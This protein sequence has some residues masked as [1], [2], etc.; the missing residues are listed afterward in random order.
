MLSVGAVYGG[1]PN[2]H[3]I[4]ASLSW[5]SDGLRTA[6]FFESAHERIAANSAPEFT[7]KRYSIPKFALRTLCQ[8]GFEKLESLGVWIQDRDGTR[9]VLRESIYEPSVIIDIFG[10][11]EED[12]WVDH[13]GEDFRRLSSRIA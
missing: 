7:H 13:L 3:L 10:S 11:L 9:I 4:D 8:R 12:H 1:E 6:S 5:S 2:G